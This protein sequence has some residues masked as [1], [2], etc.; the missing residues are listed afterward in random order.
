[1]A[2]LEAALGT[3]AMAR[4]AALLARAEDGDANNDDEG[5]SSGRAG[6]GQR[7]S[8]KKPHQRVTK[9][10]LPAVISTAQTLPDGTMLMR[11]V[12][13]RFSRPPLSPRIQAIVDRAS[14]ANA[15]A[16]GASGAAKASPHQA[17]GREVPQTQGS[18]GRSSSSKST[19][20]R[21]SGRVASEA[22]GAMTVD[23][24]CERMDEIEALLHNLPESLQ[25]QVRQQYSVLRQVNPAHSLY[26]CPACPYGTAKATNIK[27]HRQ[28]FNH[29]GAEAGISPIQLIKVKLPPIHVRGEA[30]AAQVKAALAKQARKL[31]AMAAGRYA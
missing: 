1:M 21:P 2:D 20:P 12:V 9:R 14:A 23:E 13:E 30:R 4:L 16:L 11:R 15:A 8:G 3:S 25:I 6:R 5:A 26:M 19:R 17:C 31:K 29:F 28:S 7:A 10:C 18:R 22:I 24:A 27:R